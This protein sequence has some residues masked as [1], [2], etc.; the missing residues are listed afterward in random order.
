MVL[1]IIALILFLPFLLK[2]KTDTHWDLLM[3]GLY[4]L[5]G[6]LGTSVAFYFRQRERE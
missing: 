2:P 5:T 4:G 1:V 3:Y 6:I